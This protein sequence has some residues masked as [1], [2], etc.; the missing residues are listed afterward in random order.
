MDEGLTS[1]YAGMLLRLFISPEE[2]P[3]SI[4]WKG[5]QWDVFLELVRKN[6]LLVRS[7][8]RLSRI[9]S[10]RPHSSYLE[11]VE[12]E[13]DRIRRTIELVEKLSALCAEAKIPHIFPKAFQHYPDMGHDVDLFVLD[14]SRKVDTIIT[15][16]FR[17][18]PSNGSLLNALSG[19][20]SLKIEDYP[21]PVEIHHG[22]M[23]HVGEHNRYPVI[24]MENKKDYSIDGVTVPVPSPEDSLII[25]AM[26]RIYGHMCIRLSDVIN[27]ISLVQRNDLNWDYLLGVTG[28]IGIS[29]GLCCY[30]SYIEQIYRLLSRSPLFCE[31]LRG[32]LQL[33]GWGGVWFSEGYYRF[34]TFKTLSIVYLRKFI[35]ETLMHNWESA[36]RLTLL[37]LAGVLTR[38]R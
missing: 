27:T 35:H 29:C 3:D 12:G 18:S 1:R 13:R 11:A 19:K 34:P 17:V 37:P 16:N 15:R 10:L 32:K 6:L 26:Q 21:S 14:C 36:G 38:L 30:L 4:E 24:L 2:E 7:Y 20:T 8:E 9:N 5:I 28:E 22:R 23:G 31:P 33:N 25:Q